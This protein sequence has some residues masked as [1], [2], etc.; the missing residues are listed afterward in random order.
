MIPSS[1]AAVESRSAPSGLS[2]AEARARR[3]RGQGNTAPPRTGR[4]YREIVVENVLTFPN[5]SLLLLGVALVLLGRPL[6]GV[7]SVGI[8]SL[9]V[10]VGVVQEV[11]AK[12]TLDRVALLTRPKATVVRDGQERPVAPE[13]LVLGDVLVVD[14]G[15]QVVVDGRVT[16]D[17]R[18]AVDESQLTGESELVPKQAGDPVYSGSFCATG[19]AHYVAEH[20]GPGSLAGQLTTGARAFRRVQTPLQR[21]VDLVIRLQLLIVGYV[22][23]LLL[24]RSLLTETDLATSV[25]NATV[26]A[27][28]VPN[29]L[30]LSISVAYALAAVRIVRQGILVQQGNAV[31]S[32]SN[33]DTLCLDKTGTLTA[34]R[35]R[36]EGLFPASAEISTTELGRILGAM[37]ASATSQNKTTAAIAAAYPAR[38]HRLVGEVPFSSDR[39]WSA[40]AFDDAD[41]VDGPP[42]RGVYVLGATEMLRPYLDAGS[43]GAAWGAIDAQTRALTGQGLRV[44]L[45]AHAPTPSLDGSG[46]QPRPPAGAVPLGLVSLAD[47]LRPEARE[48]LAAFSRAGVRPKIISGDDPETVAALARQAGLGPELGL[49]SGPQLRGMDDAALGAAAASNTV[50]GRVSPRQK[51]QLVRALRGQ[52]AYVG[53]IGDGVNDVLSLKAANLGIAMQGGSQAARGVADLVLLDDSFASLVPALTEGRRVVNGMLPIL[54]LFLTRIGTVGI[55]I[56]SAL[57]VGEFPIVLRQA[58]LVALWSVGVPSVFL[59]LWAQAAPVSKEGIG[60]RVAQFVFPQVLLSGGIALLLFY[61]TLLLGP[62]HAGM[63]GRHLPEAALRSL[64]AAGLPVAQTAVATFLVLSGLLLVVFAVPP[65]P[66][67]VAVEQEN[68]DR[69]PALLAVALAAAFA[70]VCAVPPL[71]SL[72]AL[73]PLGPAEIALVGG[74]LAVWVVLVRSGWRSHWI[75]RFLGLD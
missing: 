41:P 37:A 26:V 13:E 51:E 15:D 20:V 9:N 65:S 52:G 18:M 74:A 48:S 19:R 34:N 2:E 7:V 43:D 33:V 69:R 75:S 72:F 27:G 30:Y 70:V 16:G 25:Q 66:W 60:R 10:L 1:E 8:I 47:E 63:L 55:V 54:Q 56:L 6:D 21:G 29:G 11:R 62:A 45:L 46:D 38:P 36:V 42:L 5:V 39:K 31:E 67:W 22:E 3:A 57:V 12:R 4:S 64:Y 28:L 50:F 58:S 61:G 14:A 53:M 71:A 23:F 17:G 35:L 32:L 40:V 59:A 44:L 68:G 49:V 24:V 73:S